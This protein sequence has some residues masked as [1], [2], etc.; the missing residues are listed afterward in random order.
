MT[1]IDHHTFCIGFPLEQIRSWSIYPGEKENTLSI[2]TEKDFYQAITNALS[3][4]NLHLIPIGGDYFTRKREQ[5][6]DA[7]NLLAIKPGLVISYGRNVNTNKNLRAA[8]IE[9]LTIAGEELGRGRGGSH[10]MTCPLLRE[11]LT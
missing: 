8:G 7:S 4:K 9:V 10:C 11:E 6:S 5:W 1:H 3:T 2:V